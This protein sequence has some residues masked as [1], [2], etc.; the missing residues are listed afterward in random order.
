ML[1]DI[2]LLLY[3]MLC[4]LV[5][6]SSSNAN[7]CTVNIIITLFIK[8]FYISSQMEPLVKI[9][10]PKSLVIKYQLR[11]HYG[12]G[13][14]LFESKSVVYPLNSIDSRSREVWQSTFRR[15]IHYSQLMYLDIIQGH[16]SWD[17]LDF[18]SSCFICYTY[19]CKKKFY[20]SFQRINHKKLSLHLILLTN[21][22]YG[23]V[24]LDLLV[25]A[26]L[27]VCTCKA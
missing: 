22:C 4:R 1:N 7:D 14:Y 16:T 6:T 15:I 12:H 19:H 24:F 20:W 26:P 23:S 5:N 13:L 25:S 10:S 27:Y 9:R 18:Y 8:L 21:Q 11:E 3:A 17:C 2:I